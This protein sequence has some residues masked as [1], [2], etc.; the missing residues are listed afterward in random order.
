MKYI[1]LLFLIIFLDNNVHAQETISTNLNYKATYELTFQPDSTDV[2]SVKKENVILFIG[3]D[4]SVFASEGRILKDSLSAKTSIEGVRNMNFEERAN[5]TK[6]DFNYVIYKGFPEEKTSYNYKIIRDN[7]RYEEELNQ[8]SWE[9]LPDTKEIKG[10][11][12]QKARTHFAGRNYTGYF[13]TEIPISEGPYKFNGLPGL[14]LEI[15]DDKGHYNFKLI[16]FERYNKPVPIEVKES[17]YI[18]TGKDKLQELKKEFALNPFAVLERSNSATKKVTIQ[19]K[20]G[21]K[22]ELLKKAK[23]EY[24][25]KNNPIELEKKK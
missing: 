5:R 20:D 8:F 10:Y 18:K 12:A 1:Y 7:F 9:I 11:I 25:K 4:L 21:Q 22:E 2:S 16:S 24:L 17:D 14:I 23:E 19:F 15:E 3:E 6:T 13:T